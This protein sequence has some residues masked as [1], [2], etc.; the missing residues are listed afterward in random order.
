METGSGTWVNILKNKY[1]QNKCLSGIEMKPGD[2]Q[3]WSSLMGVKKYFQHVK[4]KL[5]DENE[6]RYW[7]DWWVGSKPL[8]DLYP[9]L[10]NISFDH[11]ILVA[12]AINRGWQ[13]FSFR[14][15]L[16]GETK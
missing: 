12:E 10:Y 2:S 15:T 13:G 8:K 4:K 1:V 7:E 3:F 11:N 6:S 5:G 16:T 14:R 9:R